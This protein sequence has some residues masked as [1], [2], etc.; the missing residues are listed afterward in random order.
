MEQFR[1]VDVVRRDAELASAL[2][3]SVPAALGEL[4]AQHGATVHAVAAVGTRDVQRAGELTSAVFAAAWQRSSEIE[5]GDDF[6]PWLVRLLRQLDDDGGGAL[7]GDEVVW[8]VRSAVDSLAPER[9]EVLRLHHLEQLDRPTIAERLDTDTGQVDADLDR[10]QRRVARLVEPAAGGADGDTA[11]LLADELFWSE[12]PPDLGQSITGAVAVDVEPSTDEAPSG[13]AG[14]FARRSWIRPGIIG[15]ALAVLTIF[16]GVVVLS[17][18]SGTPERDTTDVELTPTGVVADAS[19][20]VRVTSF[21]AGLELVLEAPTLPRQID[22]AFYQAWVGTDDGQ[23]IPAGTF[24]QGGRITLW[25]GV[26]RERAVSFVITLE[27][28]ASGDDIGQASSDDVVL[29]ASL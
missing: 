5:P 29:R 15:A 16:G 25:A 3:R 4:Y 26:E 24:R 21:D 17:A 8:A 19:G 7:A 18:L 2:H 6:A 10:A 28:P 12:P 11:A 1:P 23:L 9:R 14:A 20:T 22:G 13:L 27:A